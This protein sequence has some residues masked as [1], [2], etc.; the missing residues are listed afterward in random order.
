MKKVILN[1]PEDVAQE[2]GNK[3]SKLIKEFDI[4][5][6]NDGVLD[7]L[8]PITERVKTFEDA[9]KVLSGRAEAGDEDAALLLADYESNADNIKTSGIVA[10]MKLCIITAALN[11]GWKPT[12]SK[13]EYRWFPWFRYYTKEEIEKM[14]EEE[15]LKLGL[16]GAYA[17]YGSR[18]GLAFVDSYDAWSRTGTGLGSRLAYKS[19]ALADYSGKQFKDIW[20]DYVGKF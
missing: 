12:F 18:C 9:C 4:Q 5:E 7:C 14:S 15:R 8:L 20:V 6:D 17:H 11:E 1:V 2:L 16:V 19:E 3:L 13:D 10:F